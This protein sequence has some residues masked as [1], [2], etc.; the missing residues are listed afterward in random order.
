MTRW[1]SF[2]AAGIPGPGGSKIA[3]HNKVTEKT[4]VRDA[5]GKK[6]KE[7][8]KA[9]ALEARR[10]FPRNPKFVDT[11]LIVDCRFELRRPKNHFTA[12]G[13]L[14]DDAPKYPI[15][16]PDSTKLFRSTEDALQDIAF[17]NDSRIVA[18][19]VSKVYAPLHRSKQEAMTGWLR[20]DQSDVVKQVS[21]LYFQ[22]SGAKITIS[23]VT[24]DVRSA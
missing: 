16:Q 21:K 15:V 19:H 13:E 6:T 20:E 9:V 11:P 7:W 4:W 10:W 5:G 3:A 22:R 2:Y 12:K 24:P 17:D 8:R 18:Q 23:E 14:R 1:V